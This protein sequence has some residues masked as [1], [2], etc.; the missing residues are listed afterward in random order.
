LNRYCSICV[1]KFRTI[2]LANLFAE[3][4]NTIAHKLPS[5]PRRRPSDGVDAP[6]HRH[7]TCGGA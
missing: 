7:E 5:A 3:F 4:F 1:E 2:L 6:R